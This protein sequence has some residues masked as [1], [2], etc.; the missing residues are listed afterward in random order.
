MA[1]DMANNQAV[2]MQ[3]TPSLQIL[4]MLQ[5][6]VRQK[7]KISNFCFLY[8]ILLFYHALPDNLFS[9]NISLEIFS[10]QE[11]DTP[12][13]QTFEFSIVVSSS[14]LISDRHLFSMTRQV[15]VTCITKVSSVPCHH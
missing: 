2:C 14:G 9:R 7:V 10:T 3:T 8:N 6:F 12:K 1:T 15:R 11:I 13:N 5:N 4:F